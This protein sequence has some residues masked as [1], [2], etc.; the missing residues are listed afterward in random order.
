MDWIPADN[1]PDGAEADWDE[2][3]LGGSD[4]A[5]LQYTSGSTSTPKGVMLSHDSL[6][7]N[8]RTIQ[9]C[10][11]SSQESRGVIWLP[12]FHDMGLIG[13][14]LQ[15]L[16]AGFPVTLMAP[17]AFLQEPM[18][19][20]E[21]VS[22][23][24]ATIGGGPNFAYDLCVRQTTPEERA[25]LDLS[26]WR[27][28]FN[29][30]EPVMKE[31]WTDLPRLSGS[32][33]SAGKPSIPVTNWPNLPCWSLVALPMSRRSMSRWRRGPWSMGRL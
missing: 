4:L 20:L 28:A 22:R 24:G 32:P 13:G 31:A 21:A 15:P 10:F 19:W 14:V 9:S 29:G 27:V 11:G 2:K 3:P 33:V 1:L 5:F 12:P 26:H 8:L 18:H 17:T 16:F 6:M 23:E 30:A 7:A 25:T